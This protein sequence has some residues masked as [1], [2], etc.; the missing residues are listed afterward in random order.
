MPSDLV[1]FL[2]PLLGRVAAAAVLDE[3]LKHEVIV[4]I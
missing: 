2:G 3:V 1:G 4:H